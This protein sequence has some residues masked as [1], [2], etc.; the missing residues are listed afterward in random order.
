MLVH[1]LLAGYGMT[2]PATSRGRMF[3]CFYAL[4]GIPLFLVYMATIGK[5][6]AGI[7]DALV[8]RVSR[9][10]NT[11]KKPLEAI[12]IL[13]LVVLA[14]VCVVFFPALL[15]QHT[16]SQWTYTEAVYFTIVSLTTIGYGDYIPA[17]HHLNQLNYVFL[18]V[19]WLFVG[20]A[21][22]SLLVAKMAEVYSKVEYFTVKKSKKYLTKCLLMKN[23]SQ[24]DDEDN[25]NS[26]ELS[27]SYVPM[28]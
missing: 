26:I 28:E 18:Y 5:S 20:L 17:A 19:T 15:F 14:F 13:V 10:S 2:S 7:W 27:D 23:Q 11:V 16:E 3:L 9:K 1:K 25:N 24:A 4:M 21:I 12:S 8:S 22:V 6:L